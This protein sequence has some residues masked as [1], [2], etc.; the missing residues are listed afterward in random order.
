MNTIREKA[1][2]ASVLVRAIRIQTMFDKPVD[3]DPE[4]MV[5]CNLVHLL[6]CCGSDGECSFRTSALA[7]STG[8]NTWHTY[9]TW[10]ESDV[11]KSYQT[12]GMTT[13]MTPDPVDSDVYYV[14]FN[15]K[16]LEHRVSFVDTETKYLIKRFVRGEFDSP[17][18]NDKFSAKSRTRVANMQLAF[19]EYM[20]NSLL[21]Q[22][23]RLCK[24][25]DYDVPRDELDPMDID[26]GFDDQS[27]DVYVAW[28]CDC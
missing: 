28:G 3:T 26:K 18:A 17:G 23:V 7:G 16:A 19:K 11:A 20:H 14:T 22:Y 13:I 15:D 25:K 8:H 21:P 10:S 2:S 6:L 4:D 27:A 1:G 9:D 12:A 24:N 5:E